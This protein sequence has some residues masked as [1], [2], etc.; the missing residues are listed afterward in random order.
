MKKFIPNRKH[1]LNI[2]FKVDE[3]GRELTRRETDKNWHN[4]VFSA[5]FRRRFVYT[6][7]I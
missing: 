2:H 7:T 1:E 4:F 5:R 3:D 6:I